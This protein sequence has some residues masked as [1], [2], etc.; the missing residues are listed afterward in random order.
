MR[1]DNYYLDYVGY[2]KALCDKQQQAFQNQDVLLLIDYTQK[3]AENLETYMNRASSN[4]NRSDYEKIEQ[5]IK[6]DQR[7]LKYLQCEKILEWQDARFEQHRAT[8]QTCLKHFENIKRDIEQ[9]KN[10][11]SQHSVSQNI[12]E[13]EYKTKPKNDL[14]FNF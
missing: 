14:D 4:L 11:F 9:I 3:K 6:N 2:H 5:I 1:N 7:M 13:P 8:Y 12:Y 10:P